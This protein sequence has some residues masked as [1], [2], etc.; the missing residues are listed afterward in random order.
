M[1]MLSNDMSEAILEDLNVD[2]R[3]TLADMP[4]KVKDNLL[5]IART[6]G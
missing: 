4:E 3:H 5:A 6:K 1:R 2:Q